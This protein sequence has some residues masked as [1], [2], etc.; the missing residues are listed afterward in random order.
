MKNFV[1]EG[2]ALGILF[3]CVV[4]AIILRFLFWG[5]I[6]LL[7]ASG[8]FVAIA[9]IMLSR[10]SRSV[11]ANEFYVFSI[12]FSLATALLPLSGAASLY[13]AEKFTPALQTVLASA[14]RFRAEQGEASFALL[15]TANDPISALK[16][17]TDSNGRP[18]FS[19]SEV[20]KL[21]SYG[22]TQIDMMRGKIIVSYRVRG[23]AYSSDG[24]PLRWCDFLY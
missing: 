9:G 6:Y 23:E 13:K 21:L 1:N 4:I 3:A 18:Y 2:I 20:E 7:V 11:V 10:A 14:E 24:V 22:S 17:T 5:H 12:V 19:D 15:Q 8:V 16:V